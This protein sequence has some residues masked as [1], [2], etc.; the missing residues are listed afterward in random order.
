M[1]S[2]LKEYQHFRNSLFSANFTT[3]PE[4]MYLLRGISYLCGSESGLYQGYPESLN[5]GAYSLIYACAA[6]SDYYVPFSSLVVH[7]ISSDGALELKLV[8]TPKLLGSLRVWAPDSF[9]VSFKLETDASIL[10]EKSEKALD[11]YKVHVVVANELHSRYNK[12]LLVTKIN[13]LTNITS[14][15]RDHRELE[16]SLISSVMQLHSDFFN[17]KK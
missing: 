14:I 15:E 16:L 4:Y 7:K 1:V 12:V 10:I 13:S 9:I 11:N 2:Y 5:L 3:L 17:S 8:Q 6:V